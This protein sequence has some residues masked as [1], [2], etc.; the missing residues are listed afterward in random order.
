MKIDAVY[1]VL[2]CG[3][4]QCGTCFDCHICVHNLDSQSRTKCEFYK[5]ICMTDLWSVNCDVIIPSA[6]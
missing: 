3:G 1:H 2:N 6:R 4:D 5:S